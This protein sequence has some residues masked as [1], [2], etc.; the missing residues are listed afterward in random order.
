M[1]AV[2]ARVPGSFTGCSPNGLCSSLKNLFHKSQCFESPGQN[3]T[4][5][6]AN[7]CGFPYSNSSGLQLQRKA[8][9]PPVVLS[10]NQCICHLHVTSRGWKQRKYWKMAK[11]FLECTWEYTFLLFLANGSSVFAALPGCLTEWF[12][13]KLWLQ[14]QWRPCWGYVFVLSEQTEAACCWAVAPDSLA[15]L[16]V[17][18]YLQTRMHEVVQDVCSDVFYIHMY[19]ILFRS[20]LLTAVR[21]FW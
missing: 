11:I 9:S 16:A 21:S 19:N 18:N 4:Y 20:S 3:F 1:V 13:N 2:L 17:R 15:S 5:S 7:F 8:I 14:P 10:W 12:T 6:F